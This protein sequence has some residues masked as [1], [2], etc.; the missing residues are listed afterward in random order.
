MTTTPDAFDIVVTGACDWG[1][2]T[3]TPLDAA[4]DRCGRV[5]PVMYAIE[6]S[7]VRDTSY[8][9]G[10]ACQAHIGSYIN[11]LANVA[12]EPPRIVIHRVADIEPLLITSTVTFDADFT[13]VVRDS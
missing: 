3:D 2:P 9:D 12:G 4:D 6:C 13:P 5:T 1:C 10:Y 8:I 11:W 7:T